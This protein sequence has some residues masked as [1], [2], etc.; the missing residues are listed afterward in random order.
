MKFKGKFKMII[1]IILNFLSLEFF[2]FGSENGAND[3]IPLRF[4]I[5]LYWYPGK[6]L[7]HKDGF[8]FSMKT[9]ESSCSNDFVHFPSITCRRSLQF[10][11]THFVKS[12]SKLQI[13]WL[14]Y[15]TSNEYFIISCW[16]FF[17]V[18]IRKKARK[19]ENFLRV[20]IICIGV[21]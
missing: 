8:Q 14:N 15:R 10:E 2:S 12:F 5:N 21:L 7:L 13:I 3:K 17:T 1:P 11:Q 18:S 9:L 19:H 4:Y 16:H 20:E 6:Y